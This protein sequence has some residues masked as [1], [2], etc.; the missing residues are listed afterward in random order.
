VKLSRS[1]RSFPGAEWVCIELAVAG[2]ALVLGA[3][4]EYLIPRGFSHVYCE[5]L[6]PCVPPAPP[7][8][9][10][11]T[12]VTLGMLWVGAAALLVAGIGGLLLYTS[13]AANGFLPRTLGRGE[14][15]RARWT[16]WYTGWCIGSALFLFAIFESLVGRLS[17]GGIYPFLGGPLC[18]A[19]GVVA[20][21]GGYRSALSGGRR[22]P[23]PHRAPPA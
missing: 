14:A 12:P 9:H 13:F 22:H 23:G 15:Q 6:A 4:S 16:A 3:V 8:L 11:W 5:G 10:A 18:V 7:P 1:F 17:A 21:F 20:F 2:T 19:V